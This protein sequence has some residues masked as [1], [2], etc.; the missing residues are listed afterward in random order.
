MKFHDDIPMCVILFQI[1]L[2]KEHAKVQSSEVSPVSAAAEEEMKQLKS[3]VGIDTPLC[4]HTPMWT[5]PYVD[6]S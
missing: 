5:H 1:K 6:T 4:G 2:L 3:Q